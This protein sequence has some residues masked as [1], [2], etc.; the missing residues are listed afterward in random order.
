MR[1]DIWTCMWLFFGF[2]VTLIRSRFHVK[3][4]KAI[5][6]TLFVCRL[7][8][9]LLK[10]LHWVIFQAFIES[11]RFLISSAACTII[12]STNNLGIFRKSH[13]TCLLRSVLKKDF[14]GT[15]WWLKWDVFVYFHLIPWGLWR[16][17]FFFSISSDS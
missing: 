4:E 15:W 5:E 10:F 3:N 12:I 8:K 7:L 1:R 11:E 2:I 17:I 13:W 6:L 14:C 9:K 16:K